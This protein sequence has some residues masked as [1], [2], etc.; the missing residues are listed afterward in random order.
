MKKIQ[1]VDFMRAV[2]IL[3]VLAGH[4]EKSF[5]EKGLQEGALDQLWF[6]I[7][8]NHGFGVSM[9]FVISGFLIT[10]LIALGPGGLFRP[11]FR[12]F[13]TR[14]IGRLFPLLVVICLGG[15]LIVALLSG[16]SHRD[17]VTFDPG[18]SSFDLSFWLSIA[19]FGLSG[20]V[21]PYFGI[22]GQQTAHGL[23]W[24]VLWSLQIEEQFYLCYPLLLRFL[25]TP[26][27][28]TLFLLALVVLN[29]LYIL[30]VWKTQ[31]YQMAVVGSPLSGFHLIALGCLLYL[32]SERF[33]PYLSA[34]K[35]RAILVCLSGVA[36][37]LAAYGH[38]YL[39]TDFWWRI[40]GNT[41]IGGGTF[42]LLLGG[43]H[44]RFFD[45]G[46]MAP[47]T[48][49]GR[50]SYGMYLLHSTVLFVLWPYFSGEYQFLSFGLF[51]AGTVLLSWVSHRYLEV[52]LNLS[53]RKALGRPSRARGAA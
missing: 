39:R 41:L 15:S 25:G 6:R 2:G 48:L 34:H 12:D 16:T 21:L 53:I 23:H 33:G 44:L 37:I 40:L 29:P 14:R 30:L 17:Q 5:L 9:F 47:L 20:Y 49:P 43:F 18:T 28:L 35:D 10:R 7:W 52:P 31:P 24:D 38:Y 36:L 50:L 26:R 46:W 51:A 27:R 13:Y 42:L 4:L 32:T 19:T 11:D 8:S 1:V 3:L 45:S 22:H